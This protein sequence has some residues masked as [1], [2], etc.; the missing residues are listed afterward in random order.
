MSK[1]SRIKSLRAKMGLLRPKYPPPPDIIIAFVGCDGNG[2][3]VEQECSY[4]EVDGR[5]FDRQ[6]GET[7]KDFT[8]RI[9][10]TQERHPC[11]V[12]L[13]CE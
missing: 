13:H 12:F 5:R 8:N 3:V 10:S 11:L 4:G 6:P 2:H 1:E 7:E 9:I